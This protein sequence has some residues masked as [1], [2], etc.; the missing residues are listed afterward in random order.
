[1]ILANDDRPRTMHAEAERTER[2]FFPKRSPR[3]SNATTHVAA[4]ARPPG[5]PT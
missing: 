5:G 4:P 3:L 1:M 2:H